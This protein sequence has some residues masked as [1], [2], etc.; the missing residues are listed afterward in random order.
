[1]YGAFLTLNCSKS[2]GF[3]WC[4][5]KIWKFEIFK[6]LLLNFWSFCRQTFCNLLVVGTIKAIRNFGV[7][8]CVSDFL[9]CCFERG[10]TGYDI[11]KQKALVDN[12]WKA[13]VKRNT[14]KSGTQDTSRTPMGYLWLLGVEGNFEALRYNFRHNFLKIMARNSKHKTACN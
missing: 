12:V 11:G 1:M 7:L 8:H 9:G 5:C 2:F 10:S 6:M 4:T 13:I 14:L 3:T